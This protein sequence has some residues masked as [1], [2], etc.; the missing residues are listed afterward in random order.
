MS[1]LPLR[2]PFLT[3]LAP[4]GIPAGSVLLVTFLPH[5]LWY[6]ASYTLSAQ[7][8]AAGIPTDYHV[9]QR[10]PGDVRTALARLGARAPGARRS[11]PFRLL[12]SYTVQTGRAVEL[13]EGPYRFVSEGLHLRDWRSP[14]LSILADP[15]ERDRLHIDDNDSVLARA[16]S[17]D[18]ILDFFQSRALDGAR[19]SGVTFLH[20][21]VAGAHSRRFYRHLESLVDGIIDFASWEGQDAIE[22]VARLRMFRGRATDT[23]WRALGLSHRGAVRSHGV[24][25]SPRVPPALASIPREFPSV[26]ETTLPPNLR[27]PNAWL[28]LQDLTNAFLED[29]RTGGNPSEEAGWRSLVQIARSAKISLSTLYPRGGLASPAIRE[30]GAAGLIESRLVAG[31]RGRGGVA[32]N[33]RV[34]SHSHFVQSRLRQLGELS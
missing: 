10:P 4:N 25:R 27:T 29:S 30:L 3:S 9:F 13:A 1:G 7:A 23:R 19:E 26:P 22:Q 32:V 8:L 34:A 21:F 20:G 5:S 33:L 24:V 14:A 11:G 31:S 28:V 6:E 12:D 16:N 18:E 17:E 15:H 2:L